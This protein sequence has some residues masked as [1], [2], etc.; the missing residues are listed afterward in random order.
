MFL[1]QRQNDLKINKYNSY[2]E[3]EKIALFGKL[4]DTSRKKKCWPVCFKL[5]QIGQPHPHYLWLLVTCNN[6]KRHVL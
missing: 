4:Q 1:E 3:E 5:H 2:E 6:N